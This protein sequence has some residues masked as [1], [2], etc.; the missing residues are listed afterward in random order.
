M[1]GKTKIPR[2][3]MAA[4]SNRINSNFANKLDYN[5]VVKA[6]RSRIDSLAAENADLVIAR[7][8]LIAA[9]NKLVIDISNADTFSVVDISNLT[10]NT[11]TFTL[12]S[13]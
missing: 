7:T 11:T 8:T 4:G 10:I 3:T 12:D 2:T 9:N 13:A 6:M 5:P 1:P